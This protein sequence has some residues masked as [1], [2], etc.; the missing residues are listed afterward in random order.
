MLSLMFLP[1][2]AAAQTDCGFVGMAP[3]LIASLS[4]PAPLIAPKDSNAV[5]TTATALEP[6]QPQTLATPR[7]SCDYTLSFTIRE[8]ALSPLRLAGPK[9][10]PRSRALPFPMTFEG[11]AQIERW[12]LR[13]RF[14]RFD[15]SP[16]SA[17]RSYRVG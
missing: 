12:K 6:N 10:T 4:D 8:P 3:A 7:F 17:C 5:P 1:E 16:G 14:Q 15:R 2:I 13:I 9:P 11:S